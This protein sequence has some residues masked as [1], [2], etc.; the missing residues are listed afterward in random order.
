[1]SWVDEHACHKASYETDRQRLSWLQPQMTGKLLPEITTDFLII[2]RKRKTGANATI[3]RH[4]A[5]VSAVLHHARAKGWILAVP[6]IPYLP[7]PKERIRWITKLEAKKL[8]ANLPDHLAS[9]ARFALSTGL[10][11]SNVTGLMWQ[12]VDIDRKVAW[13][14]ADEAKARKPLTVPLNDDAIEVLTKQ[15]GKDTRYVFAWRGKPIA[16]T[17]T[18]AFKQA[19]QKAGIQD[20]SWHDLRHTWASWH[21]MAGT[22]LD[23]LRQLGGWADM[24]MVLR[25]AHLSPG[26]VAGYA[27]NVSLT[28]SPTTEIDVSEDSDES[29]V[30]VGWPMG[31]EPTTTG[32]TIRDSTN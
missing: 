18:K 21:V 14:W 16:E 19:C 29:T 8:L 10:R 17:N 1:M 5:L 28:I 15:K 9:M 13:V 26:Y 4:L 30:A 7:E 2:L 24:A 22:P 6:K 11:R 25:Y 23:V 3:N 32:I 20:F 31:L 27:G 12:N